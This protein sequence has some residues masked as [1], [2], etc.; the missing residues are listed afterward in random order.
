MINIWKKEN[1]SIIIVSHNIKNI[2]L[3]IDNI[4]KIKNKNLILC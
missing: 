1:R 2:D 3:L 4:Y